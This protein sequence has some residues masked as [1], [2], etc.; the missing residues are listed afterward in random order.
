VLSSEANRPA[1]LG[2]PLRLLFNG[3]I[4]CVTL[5]GSAP[6]SKRSGTAVANGSVVEQV[7]RAYSST[8]FPPVIRVAN[9]L[10]ARPEGS[11]RLKD[12][13]GVLQLES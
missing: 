5:A 4:I 11:V 9:Y 3:V 13:C 1:R 2:M 8:P 12:C 7:L 6:P 10:I